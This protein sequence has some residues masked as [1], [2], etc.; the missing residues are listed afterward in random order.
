MD[1]CIVFHFQKLDIYQLSKEIAKDCYS[2]TKKFPS[3]EKFALVPQVY[4]AAISVP[5]NIAEGVSRKGKKDQIHFLNISYAS[6]MELVCQ[7]EISQEIGYLDDTELASF[8]QKAN[9]LAVK[10]NNYTNYVKRLAE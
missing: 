9:N 5:S 10:M 6:L 4:R 8:K 7:I 2:M 3:E 1:N